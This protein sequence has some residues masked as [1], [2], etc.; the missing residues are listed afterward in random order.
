MPDAPPFQGDLERS[1]ATYESLIGAF[2]SRT[3]EMID[4]YGAVGALSRLVISA[5]LQQGFKV[6][7][8]RRKL[9][10]TFEAVVT[11]HPEKFEAATIEA[12]Q[13]RL[14]NAENLH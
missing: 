14:D 8:D 3:R 1:L 11:R 12:A 10:A 13:W 2:A 5:D 6:L 7:R 9:G 4:R